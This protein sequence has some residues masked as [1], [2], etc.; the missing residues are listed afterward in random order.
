MKRAIVTTV[1]MTAAV[2]AWGAAEH[3]PKPIVF[4]TPA[5]DENG[6][7]VLGNGEVGA[8]AWLGA[9]GTLHTVLQNSDSWNEGGRHVKTGAIDY[10]TKSPID[11]G[12]YRQE[13]SLARGEFEASWK[14]GGQAVSLRY[15]IQQG[16]DSIAV[17]DV[18]GA[19]EVEA[20][21]V[22]WRL[23]PGG[24]KEF[25]VGEYELGNR[26]CEGKYQKN[27]SGL[28]FTVNADR[29]VPG[30]WCHVNRNETVAEMMK[31]YDYYQATGDLG[32][33]DLLSNRVFGG[34]TRS[35]SAPHDVLFLTAIT[36]LHPCKDE[37]EW[38]RR[39]NEMLDRDGW[40]IA[41][42]EAK[43][44]EHIA[45]WAQ[46]WERSHIVVA[47]AAGAASKLR[48]DVVFPTND[49][50]PL[51]FGVD[52]K[53]HNRFLGTFASAEVEFNGHVVYSG[54]P[55][56]GDTVDRDVLASA[57]KIGRSPRDRRA[58]KI[59]RFACRFATD[60]PGKPQRLLDNITPGKGD[61]FL[62][63]AYKGHVRFIAG[64]HVFTHPLKL[65]AGSEIALEVVVPR[66][67]IAKIAVNGMSETIGFGAETVAEECAAVT[68][69]YAAQ[70]YLTSCAGRG[71]LPIRFNGSIFTISYKGDPD[72]RRWG[73]GYWWQNT[74]LPYYPMFAAGD[75]DQLHPLFRL[76]LGLLDFSVKR[77][78][79]YLNH[80]GAYI[81]EC[82]QPWGDHFIGSYGP[83]C[84]WKD[85]PDKL[86]EHGYHKYEWLCQLELSL[87]LLN[88]R[89]YT[90]DDAWFKEKALPAI[91]EY[92]RYFD[93]HYGLDAKGRYLMHPAQAAE[94]WW[95]CTNPMTEVS[96]LMRV[97]DLLL[98]LPDGVLS[99][100]DR[101]LFAK[102]RA[103]VPDL[104][105][106]KLDDGGIVFA[107]GE[108]FAMHHNC[109]TPELYCVFPFRLCSF[110]KPNAEIGRRTYRDGRFHK[111]Y[112]GW[113]QDEMNAAYLGL[114]E[115]AREHIA[116]RALTHS[117]KIY[118]WPAYWGPNFDWCP[119]QDEG[120][121]FQ[122]TIQS[123]L[124]QVE[125][126]KIFLMP[127]WPKDWN[128]LFKLHAPCNT[129]VEGRI[130]NG[131]VK[132]L[133]VTPASR[134]ADIVVKKTDTDLFR[135]APT[136]FFETAAPK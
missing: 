19:P 79:K 57:Q 78:R 115:E 110:E 107:P 48:K 8:T 51:S 131:E 93:E 89:A 58:D 14:S 13:L 88:Y 72:Y 17:C 47:P 5:E 123:M 56:P 10:E 98:A 74:R 32:K 46:F 42:E 94:T 114:T 87:L 118:R 43:R 73:S 136:A 70:R 99:P 68:T 23:Y 96:G 129:T 83:I 4:D 36:S 12:T 111:L 66:V 120:G 133:V 11:A 2:V 130:E 35:A 50:L 6:V 90:G 95:D 40:D 85:R 134:L 18:R 67:G 113:S 104:P 76:H 34:V 1:C 16:T 52:S 63:D 33:P 65:P 37:A 91:R 29:L 55:K 27:V 60:H 103:R 25:G 116:D 80:G 119:D 53:G 69:A 59:F 132:D 105:V 126:K 26:F 20:R 100:E 3:A 125:G 127:A 38:L 135:A 24:A 61:G 82:I 97:T 101:A 117:K 92:V 22:N 15:R 109:E 106:R 45:A 81:P 75:F 7:M 86:Q 49:K 31:V 102:I 128:C 121:I 112:R 108:K 62:I 64:G 84:E 39:T 122:N 77:T 71:R 9:D 21:V 54:V 41:G 44:A 30:G 28:K 124:L